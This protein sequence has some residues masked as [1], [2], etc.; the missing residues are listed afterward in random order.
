MAGSI[1]QP[2][3]LTDYSGSV[4]YASSLCK[5]LQLRRTR[6]FFP[7]DVRSHCQYS[8]CLLTEGWPGL[9]DLSGLVEYEDCAPANGY[10]SQY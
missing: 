5:N 10:P 7:S 3:L 9:V 1:E 2:A 4:K 8:F 6:R